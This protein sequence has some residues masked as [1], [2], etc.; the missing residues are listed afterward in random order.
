MPQDHQKDAYQNESAKLVSGFASAVESSSQKLTR[1]NSDPHDPKVMELPNVSI[2]YIRPNGVD[3]SRVIL[4]DESSAFSDSGFSF[5]FTTEGGKRIKKEIIMKFESLPGNPLEVI[6]ESVLGLEEVEILAKF[7]ANPT[8]YSDLA[9]NL[10]VLT[11]K[12]RE[13]ER[14]DRERFESDLDELREDSEY[15]VLSFKNGISWE[16]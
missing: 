10:M 12:E 14:E 1:E 4:K 7:A 11:E 3:S 15:P 16:H 9:K 8:L 2:T 13:A 6:S 5:H